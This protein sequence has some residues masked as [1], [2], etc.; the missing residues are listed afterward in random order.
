MFTMKD[1]IKQEI[2]EIESSI[3]SWEDELVA[4]RKEV[5]YDNDEW[6]DLF[7]KVRANRNYIKA[8]EQILKD[9]P[10]EVGSY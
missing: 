10:Y 3:E 5:D 1:R 2:E 7:N 8:Y 9:F 4:M 6:T